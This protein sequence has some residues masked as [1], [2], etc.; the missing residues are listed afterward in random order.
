MKPIQIV[1]VSHNTVPY[2]RRC[3]E[4]I[5]AYNHHPF[6]FPYRLVV[7]EN[8]STD[9][10]RDYLAM[11]EGPMDTI[12]NEENLGWVR[13]ANQG[14]EW[15]L[16]MKPDYVVLANSDIV[17][18]DPWWFHRV[19][20]TLEQEDVGALGPVSNY[21]MGLQNIGYK[22]LP[23]VHETKFLIGFFVILKAK[24][25]REVGLLDER[26]GLGGNDDLDLSIRIR[27]A[28][29]RLMVD[30]R[31][32]IHHYGSMTLL[33]IFGGWEKIAEQD[34]KTRKILIEK[35]GKER[36]KELFTIPEELRRPS[37]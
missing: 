31:F 37:G 34:A 9:G 14:L 20:E 15:A 25:L 35:W 26:F 30:R 5:I 11:L 24:V 27:E 17:V 6:N 36:V 32:F 1:V 22:G 8:G 2:L 10:T 4:S 18:P 19:A 13:G 33:P 28:G 16:N 29:Y 21:V 3:L 7:V 23:A 12:Y